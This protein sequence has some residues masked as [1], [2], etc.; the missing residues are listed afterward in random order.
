M[1]GMDSWDASESGEILK[2]LQYLIRF[3]KLVEFYQVVGPLLLKLLQT[4]RS[5]LLKVW[6][7]YFASFGSTR[8]TKL[9]TR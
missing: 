4:W 9:S 1:A 6:K 8:L 5:D 2:K 3:L 7:N